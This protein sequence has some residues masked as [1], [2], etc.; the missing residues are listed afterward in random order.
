MHDFSII[1]YI[2]FRYHVAKNVI[3]NAHI[4]TKHIS[5]FQNQRNNIYQENTILV[6][7]VRRGFFYL[8]S[9]PNYHEESAFSADTNQ[10]NVLEWVPRINLLQQEYSTID[11][12]YSSSTI[13]SILE[14]QDTLGSTSAAIHVVGNDEQRFHLLS[15]HD[16]E[17]RRSLL[18]TEVCI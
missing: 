16:L 7:Q 14:N 1:N 3:N 11:V 15:T 5:Y 4:G 18:E 13:S 12:P 9:L 8:G 6:P 10:L 17:L 2:Y